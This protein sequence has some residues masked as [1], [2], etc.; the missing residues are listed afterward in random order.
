MKH[1]KPITVIVLAVCVYFALAYPNNQLNK[2]GVLSIGAIALV[3]LLPRYKATWIVSAV[4]MV[5][6]Y[7]WPL[8]AGTPA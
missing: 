5:M 4:L 2:A 3:V 7:L 6:A 8:L 1:V